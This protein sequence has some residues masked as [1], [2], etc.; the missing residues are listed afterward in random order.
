MS[1]IKY[2]F[3]ISLLL[4]L[5]LWQ[6]YGLAA[7]NP[8]RSDDALQH[9][10]LLLSE[11]LNP[12]RATIERVFNPIGEGQSLLIRAYVSGPQELVYRPLFSE[13]EDGSLISSH[14]DSFI[15]R[16]LPGTELKEVLVN[17]EANKDH[18]ELFFG[19]FRYSVTPD[20]S[21]ASHISARHEAAPF[22]TQNFQTLFI[23]QPSAALGIRYLFDQQNAQ[24]KQ[25]IIQLKKEYKDS[26][27]GEL[28]VTSDGDILNH[29]R[30]EM[31]EAINVEPVYFIEQYYLD[32]T[33]TIRYYIQPDGLQ[34]Y[35]LGETGEARAG[36][37]ISRRHMQKPR[38]FAPSQ[39][40]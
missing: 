31:Y 23:D 39:N 17:F 13:S 19:N 20:M 8:E 35:H 24:G 36:S 2:V 5:S 25:A 1:L 18:Y 12:D 10:R 6:P 26:T 28:M 9:F 40:P 16:T 37:W 11:Q 32:D 33:G 30:F 14:P 3:N 4:T 15:L 21:D 38:L 7:E 34:S 22:L 29:Y 27:T